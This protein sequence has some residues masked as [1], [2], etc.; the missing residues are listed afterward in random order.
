MKGLFGDRSGPVEGG[1]GDQ[2][3]AVQFRQQAAEPLGGQLVLLHEFVI[4]RIVTEIFQYVCRIY[5]DLTDFTI[6]IYSNFTRFY[7]HPCC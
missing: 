7:A 2:T 5:S 1:L 3:F 6:E 4:R